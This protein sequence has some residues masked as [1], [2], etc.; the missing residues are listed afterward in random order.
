MK[1]RSAASSQ[2]DYQPH[3]QLRHRLVGAV[4]LVTLAVLVIPLL[5]TERGT[6]P[7][8][9]DDAGGKQTFSLDMESPTVDGQTAPVTSGN[10][11]EETGA[12]AKP[13]LVE[14][15]QESPK[16]TQAAVQN[17]TTGDADAGDNKAQGGVEPAGDGEGQG[18]ADTAANDAAQDDTATAKDNKEQPPS[19][20]VPATSADGWT[21][22]VGTFSLQENVDSVLATLAKNGFKARKTRVKTSLGSD[23]TRIWLGP[24]AREETAGEV[25][26]RLASLT[27]EKGYVVKHAP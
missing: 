15:E 3:Y 26:E 27:G 4:I 8:P 14:S 1:P 13:A 17:A 5:L 23:A 19:P 11:E 10:A 24:Y 16:T 12:P 18:G 20:P 2:S 25:S 7:D 9:R 21:V 6:A 22:R